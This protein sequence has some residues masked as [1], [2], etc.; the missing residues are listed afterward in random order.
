VRYSGWVTFAFFRDCLGF[1]KADLVTSHLEL[2]VLEVYLLLLD[3]SEDLV[4]LR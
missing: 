2:V 3:L 4:P 1:A